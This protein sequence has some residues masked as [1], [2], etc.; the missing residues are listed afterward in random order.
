MV[1]S[2]QGL[3]VNLTTPDGGEVLTPGQQV[4]IEWQS[5][6]ASSHAV[7]LS[8][9]GGNTFTDISP[10][11][12]GS[13]Q[14]FLWTVPNVSTSQARIRIAARD[15]LDNRVTDDSNASFSIQAAQQQQLSVRV[16][17]PNGG[18]IFQ[19]GQQ[20]SIQWQ[21]TGAQSQSVKLSTDGGASF[22]DISPQLSGIAQSFLWTVPNQPTTRARVR[23]AV[24]DAADNRQT[25]DSDFDFTIQA[26]SQPLAVTV[27]APNGGETFEPGQQVNITWQSTGAVSHAVKLSTDGGFSFVDISPSLPGTT[28]SFLWTVPNQPTALARIRVAVRDAADNRATDDSNA[29]FIIQAAAPPLTLQVL[30]P[31]GGETFQPGQQVNVAWQSTGAVSHE[32]KFS[33]DGGLTFIDISPQ[34]SGAAQNFFWTVPNQ[35]TTQGRIRVAARDALSNRVTDDSNFGFT[36][37]PPAPL[38]LVQVLSPNGDENFQPGQQVNIIWQ[39]SGAVS[40]E[41]KFSRD[42]GAT[43]TD[44][45]PS[46][47]GTTQSFLWT[48]PNQPTT[49]ARI[50]VAARDSTSN[51]VTDDS[52]ADFVIQQPPP[53]TQLTI[54][55]L[56]PNGGE[57]LRAGQQVTIQWQSTGAQSHSIKLSTDGGNT[58]P[59]DIVTQL[60]ATAQSFL[61]TVPDVAAGQARIRVAMRDAA[62]NRLTDDSDASFTIERTPPPVQLI[63]KVISPN[64]GET[65]QPGQ[66]VNI[67][68]QSAGAVSHAVRL[69]IGGGAFIDISPQLPGT[70]QNFLWT[71]PS[72]PT[73][74]ARIRVAVRDAADNRATDDSDGNFKIGTPPPPPPPPTPLAVKVLA[75]N[76]DETFQPG[77]RVTIRW[78]S[79]GAVSHSVKLSTDGG[80]A[81]PTDIAAELGGGVQSFDWIVPN[82]PTDKARVRVAVRD[83]AG[84]RK[85]D[86]SAANFAIEPPPAPVPARVDVLKPGAGESLKAGQQYTISWQTSGAGVARHVVRYAADG[87]NFETIADGVLP[88]SARS[89]NWI[90]PADSTTSAIVRVIARDSADKE[91]A[92][93]DSA[94][95][96]VFPAPAL[97]NVSPD[98]GATQEAGKPP[99]RQVVQINGLNFRKGATAADLP[100]VKFGQVFSDEVSFVDGMTLKALVPPRTT[101]GTVSVTVI[102]P[103]GQGDKVDKA[104]TY[105]GPR[106]A[107]R[108]RVESVST[109]TLLE[110]VKN[111]GVTLLG[112]NL[113]KAYEEGVLCLRGPEGVNVRYE[114]VSVGSDRQSQQDKIVFDVL[115]TAP[116]LGPLDR[117]ILNVLASVRPNAYK[118][119]LVESSRQMLTVVSSKS[120]VP[121]GYTSQVQRGTANPVVVAGRSL[122]NCRLKASLP[123]LTFSPSTSDEKFVIALLQVG[124]NAPDKF[125]ITVTDEQNNAVGTYEVNVVDAPAPAPTTSGGYDPVDPNTQLAPVP[126]QTL[127]ESMRELKR[128]HP[129]NPNAPKPVGQPNTQSSF[130]TTSLTLSSFTF[131]VPVFDEVRVLPFF[132]RSGGTVLVD[133]PISVK[134]GRLFGIRA[135]PLLLVFRL[136]IEIS[137]SVALVASFNPFTDV[138]FGGQSFNEFPDY[139]P[140]S[141]FPGVIVIGFEVRENIT[142]RVLFLLAIITPDER[143]V[144]VASLLLELG[145]SGDGKQLELAAGVQLRATVKQVAPTAGVD[146]V[147]DLIG[148]ALPIKDPFGTRGYYFARAT[149]RVCLPWLFDLTV[150]RFIG[151]VRET[152]PLQRSFAAEICLT[153]NDN[154]NLGRIYIVPD[155]VTLE[156]GQITRA[157]A[158]MKDKNDGIPTGGVPLPAP[159]K[160]E[161]SP[162]ELQ[163][164]PAIVEEDGTVTATALGQG[165]IFAQLK[166]SGLSFGLFP[167]S[168]LGFTAP[169]A[170]SPPEAIVGEAKLFVLARDEVVV[171]LIAG[172]ITRAEPFEPAATPSMPLAVK[173]EGSLSREDFTVSI[174]VKK[175]VQINDPLQPRMPGDQLPV[176]MV[177]FEQFFELKLLDSQMKMTDALTAKLN[178]GAA[179]TTPLPGLVITAKHEEKA[180]AKV[181]PGELPPEKPTGSELFI[182]S[183]KINQ[184]A[185]PADPMESKQ[186]GPATFVMPVTVEVTAGKVKLKKNGMSQGATSLTFDLT[187]KVDEPETYEEYYR[188]LP[189]A[190]AS[191][192][193][194]SEFL[195]LQKGFA[196]ELGGARG[197]TPKEIDDLVKKHASGFWTK[198]VE[199]AQANKTADR[200]LYLSRLQAAV[201]IRKFCTDDKNVLD[202]ARAAALIKIFERYSRGMEQLKFGNAQGE[203]KI[204]FFGFDPFDLA[205]NLT[206][207]KG[208]LSGLLALTLSGK[209]LTVK[210]MT[211]HIESVILPVRF[212]DFDSG[213]VEEVVAKVFDE[214]DMIVTCSLAS[215]DYDIDRFACRRRDYQPD[216]NYLSFRYQGDDAAVP[217]KLALAEGEFLET[218][219]PYEAIITRPNLKK[220]GFTSMSGTDVNVLLLQQ[221]FKQ[222]NVK[223]RLDTDP[224]QDEAYLPTG[225]VPDKDKKNTAILGSGRA[226]LSNESF[227]RVAAY[228]VKNKARFPYGHLHI[229]GIA[230]TDE[231]KTRDADGVLRGS[232]EVLQDLISGLALADKPLK[233]KFTAKVGATPQRKTITV[234]NN[235]AEVFNNVRRVIKVE[236]VFLDEPP[237]PPKT[238]P[239]LSPFTVLNQKKGELKPDDLLEVCQVEFKPQQVG[240]VNRAMLVRGPSGEPLFRIDLEGK[241]T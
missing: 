188:V 102:N 2:E 93:D 240:I 97:R 149:G 215:A 47:P 95:F 37:A 87:K 138:S 99:A 217:S 50:R 224:T 21:S 70:A 59:T 239:S 236:T 135:L 74:A 121:L 129:L 211:A 160:V 222:R 100:R 140:V 49:R 20:V 60:P 123:Q 171:D 14:S 67:Q 30:A 146:G 112:R 22:F 3:M 44:I 136:E 165:K 141:D 108:A 228:C 190:R 186:P 69:S 233:V 119:L 221:R 29:S 213:I 101:P 181:P 77:Q 177:P 43:F 169:T 52:D 229:P 98:N 76:G 214:V 46:L 7:K 191:L 4:N 163:G 205:S 159:S 8:L 198:A 45:S 25:D 75:P 72:Q 57:T 209:R 38:A 71:V 109:L 28:Q 82:R 218:M 94:A 207:P 58:F 196:T 90:V 137:I 92:R 226:F 81:F 40:H 154:K 197:K 68:W 235:S 13:A 116:G 24:R 33:R 173:V 212:I 1:I 35:P 31:N 204:L 17:A 152:T 142:V 86:D 73:D 130:L 158:F 84:T 79:T 131:N 232:Q 66:Q 42:G 96:S 231:P 118:D 41:V 176:K 26:A 184:G 162:S 124:P 223:E 202:N 125:S 48:V 5:S 122:K 225:P 53:P 62:D 111:I 180:P 175:P 144:F 145:I 19:P 195:D 61:W 23:V 106:Q 201:T 103:D 193:K 216:N 107:A 85:T 120:P 134:L 161:F 56:A 6:G 151:G 219:L 105:L 203:K 234:T 208:N 11:L 220:P 227:Y 153:I 199:A 55:V 166:T 117:I 189:A 156:V 179:K 210:G 16:L 64:G 192:A 114:N 126:N 148:S 230:A 34:L 83:T 147:A 194:N 27:L 238:P 143:F 9:D 127:P 172:P 167:E 170:T 157:V 155:P 65:F 164:L 206:S 187:F 36:V 133:L 200:P 15:S 80:S 91:L 12:S 88:G 32:V 104:F 128:A 54:K 182:P 89:A 110:G 178:A 237:P 113:K 78:Q 132:D 115:V 183:R 51:R 185:K 139:N 39:S 241:G 18:D 10:Q 63:V 150:A 174:K 168:V